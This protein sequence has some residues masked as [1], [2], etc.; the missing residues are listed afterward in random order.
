MKK[1]PDQLTPGHVK[2]PDSTRGAGRPARETK[3]EKQ[4]RYEAQVIA[5][6]YGK[7][8]E[9]AIEIAK[10]SLAAKAA[11]NNRNRDR[12]RKVTRARVEKRLDGRKKPEYIY[13]IHG[14]PLPGGLPG[15]GKRK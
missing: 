1:S 6:K 12:K 8:L 11:A 15:L 3:R 10:K 13:E 14:P 7:S 2:A 5:G 9:D 4:I